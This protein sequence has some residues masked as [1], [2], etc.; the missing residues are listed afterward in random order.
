MGSNPCGEHKQYPSFERQ[1]MLQLIGF[2]GAVLVVVGYFLSVKTGRP[3]LFDW[4]NVFGCA[5]MLPANLLVGSFFA[6]SL[7]LSFGI[8]GLFGL[9]K[10]YG[11]VP[12]AVE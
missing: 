2:A 1:I 11:R 7:N 10:A 6:A 5:L 12:G 3:T 9:Y 8:V 4:T